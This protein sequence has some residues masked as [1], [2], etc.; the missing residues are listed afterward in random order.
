MNKLV[1]INSRIASNNDNSYIIVELETLKAILVNVIRV[2]G[3][4]LILLEFIV[5]LLSSDTFI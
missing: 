5:K 3:K 4:E 2:R 1:A